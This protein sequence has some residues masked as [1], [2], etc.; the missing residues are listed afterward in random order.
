MTTGDPVD[1]AGR[2]D[3]MPPWVPRLLLLAVLTAL[4]LLA[5][6]WLLAR[7]R[8]LLVLLLI[9]LFLSFVLEPA[10]FY[11][12]KLG[13][14]RGLATAAV[15]AAVL[16]GLGV[17]VGV[18]L[19]PLVS[20]ATSLL[21]TL[22]EYLRDLGR[23]SE[24]FPSLRFIAEPL[25][26]ALA[27]LERSWQSYTG[28]LVGGLVGLSSTVAEFVFGTL[29]VMLFTFYLVA[30]G[31][32]FRR[33]LL[34]ALRP[35]RQREVLRLWE[36]AIEKTGGYV[37]SRLLLAAAAAL[38]TW[39]ALMVI[40]VPY[41][42]ALALWVGVVSQLVPA[43]GALLAAALPTLVALFADPPKALWVVGAL[44]AYQQV[45]NYLLS[46]R[47][48]SHTMSLHPAVAFGSVIAGASILGVVGA[49]IALPAAATIQAFVS[50]YV[51]RHEVVASE[52]TQEPV[53]EVSRRRRRG[54]VPNGL[55]ASDRPL[56]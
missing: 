50:A 16:L 43:V 52:L 29:T 2:R 10:V 46:P 21:D 11:L 8:G 34:S 30:D 7:L 9:S 27:E 53:A 3:G 56:R 42:V 22:P 37:Y 13:W 35:D 23:V 40:G 41:S 32:R 44:V 15:G 19:T 17:F 20:Q 39:A 12:S 5:F 26:E 36:V 25:A 6:L 28:N 51:H 48:T 4:S 1:E 45:E 31:P 24:R 55:G 38:F 49:L 47:I 54:R 33:V 18:T 14:R